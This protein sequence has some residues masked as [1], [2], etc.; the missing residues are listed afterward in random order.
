M[1][2]LQRAI[3]EVEKALLESKYKKK[4]SSTVE[5]LLRSLWTEKTSLAS[6][7]ERIELLLQF[8][9]NHLPRPGSIILLKKGKKRV[10]MRV[11]SATLS[12]LRLTKFT[13]KQFNKLFKKRKNGTLTE[14]LKWE[15]QP[16]YEVFPREVWN[17]NAKRFEETKDVTLSNI[18]GGPEFHYEKNQLVTELAE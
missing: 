9:L 4:N 11:K 2:D 8:Y 15:N 10:L 14:T 1:S 7:G 13:E 12:E 18:V 16:Q 5:A 6:K 17:E 3:D